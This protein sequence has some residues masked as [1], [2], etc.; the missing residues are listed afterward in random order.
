[1]ER[2]ELDVY[3]RETGKGASRKL[4]GEG[5]VPGILYGRGREP[6]PLF[7]NSRELDRVVSTEAGWNIL[8]DLKVDGKE[9]VLA[10]IS[11]YQA[12]V[13]RR[14]LT[15]IDF[16]V[17]DI[18]KKIKT[19]VPIRIVGKAEGVKQGGI[20]EVIKRTLEV[21]CMPTQIPEHIDIDVT[22]LDI[23]DGIH[24]EDVTI[25]E[26]V[27][28][29]YDTNFSIAAVV[30]PT[31]EITPEIPEEG[32][33]LEGE[34]PAEGKEAV[35]PVPGKEGAAPAAPE[36]EKGEKKGPAKGEAKEKK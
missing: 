31:L 30:A 2:L 5:N 11:D 13:F 20:M 18:T 21:R 27:E 12:D 22:N 25:P 4:R 9:N 23:G 32:V 28:C 29:I 8:L 36:G 10:M 34:A 6:L 3:K 16:K 19:E 24:I 1:M 17:L 7:V 35:P 26:G 14:N 33:P 15:H